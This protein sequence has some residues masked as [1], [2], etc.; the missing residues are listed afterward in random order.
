MP[1]LR[2][3]NVN[4]SG[5]ERVVED[6]TFKYIDSNGKIIK[7]SKT[8]ERIQTLVIPPA[9]IDVWIC[10]H[11]RGHI[12]AV[13]V[14]ARGRKQYL[15]HPSWRNQ[16][17]KKKF[18][19]MLE[20][21][22]SLADLR[23]QCL[24][25]MDQEGLPYEKSLATAIL[26]LDLGLFRI[27]MEDYAQENSTYG[28]ATLEKNHVKIKDDVAT[29]DYI[30]KSSKRRIQSISHPKTV[31]I[32]KI[33]KNRKSGGSQLLAYKDK[34]R[35]TDVTSFHINS[36]IKSMTGAN[37]SAKDFR[38][39][40][41]TNL[42]AVALAASSN[43]TSA[44]AKKKAVTRAVKEV[45]YYLGNTPAIARAS[46]IDP[47]VIDKYFQGETIE[48]ALIE[49]GYDIDEGLPAVQGTIEEAVLDLL[50]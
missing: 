13:G 18:E 50:A 16:R 45:S 22:K 28:L 9:W 41:A 42:A 39:W 31:E 38:T 46:Y 15:Y 2:R 5:I 36:F 37:F 24:Q 33:L 20:F 49:I 44:S 30:A 32:I 26:L 27:G 3:S 11:E 40:R 4:L 43:V 7:D 6:A 1:R 21:G 17:D 12:Q 14:D 29:F 34:G 10:D 23:K 19:H 47:R 48:K 35:W 8:L 25:L